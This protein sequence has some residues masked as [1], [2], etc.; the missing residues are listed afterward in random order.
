[1]Y[2]GWTIEAHGIDSLEKLWFPRKTVQNENH[3]LWLK[4][5]AKNLA[6]NTKTVNK[7]QYMCV[8]KAF[9]NYQEILLTNPKQLNS[10]IKLVLAKNVL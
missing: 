2:L 9:T 7:A 3:S 4:K 8:A 5:E 1:M 10:F 6:N